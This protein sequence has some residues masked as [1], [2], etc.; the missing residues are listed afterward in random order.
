MKEIDEYLQL[1]YK[2][3]NATDKE[4][5]DSKSEMKNHLLESVRE[6]QAEGKSEQESVR[7]AIDRFGDPYEINREL[8]KDKE[9]IKNQI[10]LMK[11]NAEFKTYEE[12]LDYNNQFK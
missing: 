2:H 6:L 4:I 7:I 9:Y 1:I 11:E 12:A 10:Y 8:P 3:L 5:A